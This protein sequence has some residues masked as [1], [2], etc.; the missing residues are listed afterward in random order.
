VIC[1]DSLSSEVVSGVWCIKR[2]H[3]IVAIMAVFVAN[4]IVTL[5]IV[6]FA[7]GKDEGESFLFKNHE[8]VPPELIMTLIFLICKK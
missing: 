7:A 1:S 3:V 2:S 4:I 6:R 5:T 8:T